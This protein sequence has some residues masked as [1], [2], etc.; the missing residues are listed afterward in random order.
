MSVPS[1]FEFATWVK[2]NEHLLR[3]PVNNRM[4]FS[5]DDFIVQVVGGPNQR[6]DFHVDPYEEWFFQIRGNMHVNVV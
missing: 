4:M 3:P 2:D 5:G 6:T 1:A